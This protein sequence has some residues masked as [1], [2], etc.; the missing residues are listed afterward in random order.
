MDSMRTSYPYLNM[1]W[2]EGH[3]LRLMRPSHIIQVGLIQF[4]FALLQL[5]TFEALARQ[6]AIAALLDSVEENIE[7]GRMETAM[8]KSLKASAADALL[9]GRVRIG[10]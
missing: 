3:P 6:R 2:C 9:T 4:G 8:L 10:D 5:P 1:L 7:R